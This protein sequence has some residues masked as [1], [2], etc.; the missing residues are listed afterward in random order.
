M[1]NLIDILN[2]VILDEGVGLA[3]RTTGQ[4]FT[5]PQGQTLAFQTLTFYP[6]TGKYADAQ[7]MDAALKKIQQSLKSPIQWTNPQAKNL[8][9]GIAHFLSETGQ[10]VYLGRYFR[11]IHPNRTENNFPHSAIPGNFTF[12]SKTGEKE[13][14]GY[15]PSE[16]LER[17]DDLS[18]SDIS[19]QVMKKFGEH[20]DEFH[21]FTAFLSAKDFPVK[22]PKGKM[23]LEAF[24]QYFCELLQP[25]AFV[26]GMEVKG[27]D[28]A[29]VAYI[30]SSTSIAGAKISFNAGAT[31]GLSDSI[32]TA[33]NGKKI[34]ISTKEGAGAMASTKNLVD[35][36]NEIDSTK[37]GRS[38]R[39]KYPEE[40]RII[41][42]LNKGTHYTGPLELAKYLELINVEEAQ[43]ILNIKEKKLGL[44]E[45]VLGMNLLSK[46]LEGW[47][48]QLL[49][50]RKQAPVVPVHALMMIIAE[51][52]CDFVNTNS[53]FG[54]AAADI[55]N[56]S[57][58]LQVHTNAT[59][60]DQYI[61]IN[62]F[63]AQYPGDAVTGVKLTFDKSY[64]TTGE[65]GKIT[66]KILKNNEKF[67]KPKVAD[68]EAPKL[69]TDK[70][71]LVKPR[72]RVDIRPPGAVTKRGKVS[73]GL[74]R[75]RR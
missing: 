15:K 22:M 45:E 32:L 40:I 69:S 27:A 9:F 11:D 23:N 41:E 20:S 1:R 42:I 37:Y 70:P 14:A 43:Q 24:K 34:K 74:G 62:N 49:D 55:L 71:V 44:G 3:R 46:K 63:T 26:K 68:P 48:K 38:I 72:T 7:E 47:Y 16:I 39:K 6:G 60:N 30:G 17:F 12:S 75:E 5:N 19:D 33:P 65:N 57:A 53:N 59:V 4:V 73:V 66:F 35:S 18:P 67:V 29:I 10:D 50:K 54:N 13:N 31:G 8:A 56:H 51:K 64:W 25:I 61:I 58:V 21:A 2:T 28:E 52:V 36:L